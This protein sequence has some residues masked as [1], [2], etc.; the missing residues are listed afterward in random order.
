[1]EVTRPRGSRHTEGQAEK[2]ASKIIHDNSGGMCKSDTESVRGT[3]RKASR[4]RKQFP[5]GTD[6]QTEEIPRQ[7]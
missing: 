5:S 2:Q 6:M 3:S 4:K 1:M 7:R